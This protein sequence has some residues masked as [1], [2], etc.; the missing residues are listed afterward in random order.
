MRVAVSLCGRYKAVTFA[1]CLNL[2]V[3]DL[4][5]VRGLGLSL[6]G[7]IRAVAQT[8]TD[9]SAGGTT[10]RRNVVLGADR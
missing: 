10:L 4:S 3:K 8:T 1:E 5:L 7:A 9:G 6:S 2:A